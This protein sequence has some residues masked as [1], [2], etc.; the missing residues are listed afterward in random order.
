MN[1]KRSLWVSEIKS[2]DIQEVKKV[3]WLLKAFNV[4]IQ[5][6]KEEE[7]LQGTA[8]S[9]TLSIVSPF[10]LRC[11]LRLKIPDIIS[12]AGPDAPLSVHEIVAQLPSDAPDV[13]AL[14]RILT[15]LSTMGILRAIKPVEGIDTPMS[16]KYALTN[17]SKTYFV[18]EEINPLSLVHFVLL[19]THPV[20]VA[21]WDHIHQRVLHG[22]D[23]FQNSRPDGKDFW[24]YAATDP[25]FNALFN[26][27]MVSLTK[28]MRDLLTI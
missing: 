23:N 1:S 3:E 25:E 9:M 6:A 10:L 2:I 7:L 24:A 17:V 11:A 16:M 8:I 15:Y 20:Y 18:S 21:A 28:G 13:D 19:Q 26:V 27:G 5:A 22:G 12:I 4:D 14:S